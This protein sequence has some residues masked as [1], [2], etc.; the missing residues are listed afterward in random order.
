MI[1][2]MRGY[3]SAGIEVEDI[4]KRLID[5]SFHAP[6][7]SFPVPGTMMIEPT[8]SEDL[9]ELDRF[10]D[11]LISIRYEIQEVTDGLADKRDNVLKNA[12][13]TLHEVT[14][15]DWKHSY[16]RG[17]AAFPVP[18]LKQNKFWASV[19][20]INNTYGDRNLICS[21]PPVESYAEESAGA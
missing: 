12:P 2:D 10:S 17:K 7:V 9:A 3:K 18:F 15:N 1:V 8:E 20:R 6:T 19:A 4:A 5:Y 16:S 14:G 11:A 21:C 13:H